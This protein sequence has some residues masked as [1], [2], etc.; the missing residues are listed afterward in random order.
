MDRLLV[1][2]SYSHDSDAHR[3]A[4]LGLAERLRGDGIEVVLDQYVEGTPAQ[5]W[6]RWML[7][8]I[9]RA[10]AVLVVCTQTYYQRFRGHG[11]PDR[12]RG[13]DWE[14]AILTNELYRDR[15][16]KQKTAR[17]LRRGTFGAPIRG[18]KANSGT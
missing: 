9:E 8:E 3:A 5:G 11:P 18:I 14:G 6:P 15:S 7:D 17:H 1:F 13:V 4:V 2:I 12:G 16:Y 10:D